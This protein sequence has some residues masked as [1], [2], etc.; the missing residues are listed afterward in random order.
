MRGSCGSLCCLLAFIFFKAKAP[1]KIRSTVTFFSKVMR[2][3]VGGTREEVLL[4]G[5]HGHLLDPG[6]D[7]W[8]DGSKE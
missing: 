8:E 1:R 4:D 3:R 5:K 7:R 2:Q 6:R